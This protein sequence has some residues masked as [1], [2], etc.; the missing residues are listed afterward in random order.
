MASFVPSANAADD[1]A[2]DAALEALGARPYHPIYAPLTDQ[3]EA[4]VKAEQATKAEDA[5]DEGAQAA[6]GTDNVYTYES[7]Y[8]HLP[9][10]MDSLDTLQEKLCA[11]QARWDYLYYHTDLWYTG[12]EFR[13]VEQ[14]ICELQP[15]VIRMREQLGLPPLQVRE[16]PLD[17]CRAK[18][19]ELKAAEEATAVASALATATATAA[20]EAAGASGV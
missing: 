10:T 12:D 4:A 17:A 6:A 7:E 19:R 8:A 1:S 5:E 18:Y 14:D 9:V 3:R 13:E 15:H 2:L 11:L 16:D 20:A